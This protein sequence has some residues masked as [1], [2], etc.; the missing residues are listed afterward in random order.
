MMV[1]TKKSGKIVEMFGCFD[2]KVVDEREHLTIIFSP[3]SL[4]IKWSNSSLTADFLA[5]YFE[6]FFPPLKEVDR[7][8]TVLTRDEVRDA[9]NYIANELIENAVKFH[10]NPELEIVFT[11]Q[12]DPMCLTFVATNSVD[13]KTMAQFTAFITEVT[14][15]DPGELLIQH[16][17][18]AAEVAST[19]SGIGFLTIMS[20]YGAR[21]GWKF[22]TTQL[23][24]AADKINVTTMVQLPIIKETFDGE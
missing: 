3:A 22:E 7:E 16:L 23:K 9:I 5:K 1:R 12:L 21:I 10:Y 15:Y 17:E 18:T 24:G 19:E 13:P 14:S 2:G 4:P 6:D 20:D 8:R 11:L